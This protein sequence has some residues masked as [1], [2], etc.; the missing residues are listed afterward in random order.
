[1]L[2][3][4]QHAIQYDQKGEFQNAII[5]YEQ[6]AYAIRQ[7]LRYERDKKVRIKLIENADKLEMRASTIKQFFNAQEKDTRRIL[8][9]K[10]R[11]A[12]KR[13]S[14]WDSIFGLDEARNFLVEQVLIPSN[15][16]E[17]FRGKKRGWKSLLLYGPSGCGKS[18]L[19][20]ALANELRDCNLQV[21]NCREL[22]CR[23]GDARV[24]FAFDQAD[25]E[26]PSIIL[27][28]DLDA[29]KE[30]PGS[31][32][33]YSNGI[34]YKADREMMKQVKAEVLSGM[35]NIKKCHEGVIVIATTSK[36]WLLSSSLRRR[37]DKRIF[38][39]TL[40]DDARVA[41]AKK[42][43]SFCHDEAISLI[44][45]ATINCSTYTIV[46]WLN[47]I[48]NTRLLA[49]QSSNWFVKQ[50]GTFRTSDEKTEN[51]IS[52]TLLDIPCNQLCIPSPTVEDVLKAL[53]NPPDSIH[54]TLLADFENSFP[55][56]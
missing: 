17:V 27:L 33:Y 51:A 31:F 56:F 11:I 14:K 34:K 20:D 7:M 46:K 1:M 44:S 5:H 38:V 43:L 23:D 48:K 9:P 19:I 25:R 53:I 50:G 12:Q 21:L 28:E 37:F 30:E 39:S 4:L 52:C 2:D 16:I 32:I 6:S 55:I 3:S 24:Q 8:Y 15:N 10:K 29:L 49:F 47:Q 45:N 35:R 18:M 22:V 42:T 36:P 40:G 54:P 41:A 26:R 13:S